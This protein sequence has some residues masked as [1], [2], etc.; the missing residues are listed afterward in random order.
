MAVDVPDQSSQLV[1]RGR[2]LHS[3]MVKPL[4][5]EPALA[6]LTKV[7]GLVN[8]QRVADEVL[9]SFRSRGMGG[10]VD[11]EHQDFG[12]ADDFLDSFFRFLALMVACVLV[13]ALSPGP[14]RIFH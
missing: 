11:L 12:C 9:G 2:R 14:K 10:T 13:Y 4:G 8:G 3:L 1:L 5:R 6:I 7:D